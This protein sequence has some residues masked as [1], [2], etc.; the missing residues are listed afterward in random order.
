MVVKCCYFVYLC[1][2]LLRPSFYQF[3]EI[4]FSVVEFCCLRFSAKYECR[5]FLFFCFKFMNCEL[6]FLSYLLFVYPLI[7]VL[8]KLTPYFPFFANIGVFTILRSIHINN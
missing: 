3:N 2:Y 7:P 5:N 1:F 8:Q 6:R 4:G